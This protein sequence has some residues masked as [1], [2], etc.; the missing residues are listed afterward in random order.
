MSIP[1]LILTRNCGVEIDQ[2]HK[3]GLLRKWPDLVGS[4]RPGAPFLIQYERTTNCRLLHTG[5]D[6]VDAFA[7]ILELPDK[8]FR[9]IDIRVA[10][11]TRE[12]SYPPPQ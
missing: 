1:I 4:V 5:G 8:I 11:L 10:Q 12:L 9:L 7:Q 2:D 3:D 6:L